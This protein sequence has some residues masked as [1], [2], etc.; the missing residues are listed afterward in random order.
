MK[1]K[2]EPNLLVRINR[3]RKGE[4][5]LFFFDENGFYETNHPITM[6]RLDGRFERVEEVKVN[7]SKE[8]IDEILE[9]EIVE[10]S[11]DEVRGHA[12]EAGIKSWHVKSIERLTNELKALGV[13]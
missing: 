3:R 10:L 11:E 12:K 9:P 2:G 6:A 5:R 1:Y 8:E 4:V 7:L 13:L